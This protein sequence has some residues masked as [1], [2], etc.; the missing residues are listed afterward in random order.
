MNQE[1]KVSRGK[2]KPLGSL[3]KEIIDF[4]KPNEWFSPEQ[5]FKATKIDVMKNKALFNSLK[6]NPNVTYSSETGRFSYKAKHVLRNKEELLEKVIKCPEGIDAEELRDAYP[7]VK[8]DI[9]SLV[10]SRKIL[11]VIN[12]ENK[13]EIL[14][15]ND[16][17][18]AINVFPEFKN[19]WSEVRIPDDVDLK[20]E[21]KQFGLK[22]MEQKKRQPIKQQKREKKRRIRKNFLTNTH[23]EDFDVEK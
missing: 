2:M 9:K 6:N 13:H 22:Q 5:I 19:M 8:Q 17:R 16:S 11:C 7:K 3:Q 15:P 12:V 18:F 21:M 14:Y 1:K 4:L 20:N 10:D 23:L